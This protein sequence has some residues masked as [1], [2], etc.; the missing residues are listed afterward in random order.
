[1]TIPECPIC[2]N[3]VEVYQAAEVRGRARY[4]HEVLGPVDPKLVV[5][6]TKLKPSREYSTALR[7]TVCKRKRRDVTIDQFGA[8]ALDTTWVWGWRAKGHGLWLRRTEED[9]EDGDNS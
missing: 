4:V 9:C 5:D 2:H 6:V 8:L 1:M 3:G 7:C